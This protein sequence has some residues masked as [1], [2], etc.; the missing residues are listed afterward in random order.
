MYNL[1]NLFKKTFGVRSLSSPWGSCTEDFLL[2]KAIE[3]LE[4]A[5][6]STEDKENL[7]ELFVKDMFHN[8]GKYS[9][10]DHAGR[11]YIRIIEDYFKGK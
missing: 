9:N 8:R 6:I 1:I 4:K 2:G 10:G 3:T 11:W 5:E 7:K